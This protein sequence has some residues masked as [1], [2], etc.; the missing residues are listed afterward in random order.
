MGVIMRSTGEKNR[1]FLWRSVASGAVAAALVAGSV[2]PANAATTTV[3]GEVN[4]TGS[5]VNY[6]TERRTT[7]TGPT[8]LYLT[9]GAGS[10]WGG[11]QTTVGTKITATGGTHQATMVTGAAPWGTIIPSGAYVVNTRFTMRAHMQP[12]SGACD[13]TWGGDLHY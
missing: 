13:N 1:S 4:C 3:S 9:N 8:Q 7:S 10:Q 6:S 5:W 2:L 12:S 11:W